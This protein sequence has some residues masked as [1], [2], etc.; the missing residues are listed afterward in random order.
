M[1]KPELPQQRHC[2]ARLGPPCGKEGPVTRLI[3]RLPVWVSGF[4]G[5][6]GMFRVQGFGM[7]LMDSLGLGFRDIWGF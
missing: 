2:H 6:L 1:P 3:F 7:M 5:M 4:F